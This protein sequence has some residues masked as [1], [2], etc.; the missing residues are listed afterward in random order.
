MKKSHKRFVILISALLC[1]SQIATTRAKTELISLDPIEIAEVIPTELQVVNGSLTNTSLESTFQVVTE[2]S[3]TFGSLSHSKLGWLLV[4]VDA[5]TSETRARLNG[6][7][8]PFSTR[9]NRQISTTDQ[10]IYYLGTAEESNSTS[11]FQMSPEMKSKAISTL[12]KSPKRL[13]S[14]SRDATDV[15]AWLQQTENKAVAMSCVVNQDECIPS[16]IKNLETDGEADIVASSE[17]V[18]IVERKTLQTVISWCPIFD[19]LPSCNDEIT[20]NGDIEDLTIAKDTLIW[21]QKEYGISEIRGM[22]MSDPTHTPFVITASS[23]GDQINPDIIFDSQKNGYIVWE[24]YNTGSLKLQYAQFVNNV[25]NEKKAIKAIGRFPKLAF[26]ER[27]SCNDLSIQIATWN[28]GKINIYSEVPSPT[29]YQTKNISLPSAAD[30]FEISLL[31]RKLDPTQ[32]QMRWRATNLLEWSPIDLSETETGIKGEIADQTTRLQL[33][34]QFL[35]DQLNC[36]DQ[37]EILSR[38]SGSS[39]DSS[40]EKLNTRDIPLDPPL[41]ENDSND[42]VKELLDAKT[43]NDIKQLLMDQDTDL[44]ATRG[45]DLDRDGLSD[46][47][48]RQNGSDPTNKDTDNGGTDDGSEVLIHHL[49]PLD[50]SDDQSIGL[51][52]INLQPRSTVPL[53]DTITGYAPRFGQSV[54]FYLVNEDRVSTSL[55]TVRSQN[56]GSFSFQVPA[57][58][59][60]AKGE[61]FVLATQVPDIKLAALFPKLSNSIAIYIYKDEDIAVGKKIIELGLEVESMTFQQGDQVLETRKKDYLEAFYIN[62]TDPI[63]IT[64]SGK[65]F[66]EDL[67]KVQIISTVI[68]SLDQKIQSIDPNDPQQFKVDVSVLPQLDTNPIDIMIRAQDEQSMMS[69]SQTLGFILKDSKHEPSY[70]HVFIGRLKGSPFHQCIGSLCRQLVILCRI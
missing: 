39:A 44:S 45:P 46:S 37:I 58:A 29:F 59:D 5:E 54:W 67:S 70:F 51:R 12:D 53:L 68:P 52:I 63:S 4:T 21:S 66:G 35:T 13:I 28:D 19:N 41:Y 14:I 11:I 25:I 20:V 31:G 18:A 34:I 42:Q 49:N 24:D 56:D 23:Q 10:F 27:A 8:L 50:S 6:N 57:L 62:D 2:K 15:L 7:P 30:E 38:D 61:T 55:G 65:I 36:V 26:D 43:Y 3:E 17:A 47:Y 69:T 1:T 40:R 16:A 48:E 32:L 33:Q 9:L 22:N 60:S 64:I